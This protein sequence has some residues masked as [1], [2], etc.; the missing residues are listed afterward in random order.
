MPQNNMGQ[1]ESSFPAPA[2]TE[3]QEN[4]TAWQ[5]NRQS[6][7]MPTFQQGIRD[8]L[9]KTP[10]GQALSG[11]DVKTA[12]PI[13]QKQVQEARLTLQKYKSGKA[14]LEQRVVENAQWYK[15]RHWDC[16]RKKESNMVEPTS[17]WL[18]NSIANKHAD[19]MDNFP[20]ANILPRE[21]GDQEE[22]KRL[23]SILPVIL[24]QNDFENTFSDL[25]DDKLIKGTGIYGVFWDGTKLNGLGDVSI[26]NVDIINLFW[27][28]GITDIQQSRNVFFVELMDNEIL[29]DRYP[30]LANKLGGDDG[31]LGKYVYDDNVDTTKKSPVIDW[32]YKKTV[33]GKNILHYCKFVNDEV[34]FA[35]EN[36]AEYRETGWYDDG[37]YPFVFDPLFRS[38]GT[39][40]GFGYIDVA[41]SAQEYIDRGNQAIMQNMLANAR[42]RHFIRTDGAVNE[43]EYAD[44][45]RDFVHVEGSNLGEDSIRAIQGKPLNEIYVSVI[46]NKI[47]E[48]K[49]TTGNRDISTGGTASGVTA[50]SAIA[51]MQEAGSKLSRD[52]NKS[53]YRAFRKMCLMVIERI[54]QFYDLPRQFRIIGEGGA[55]EFVSYDNT[56][57]RPMQQGSIM[58]QDMGIRMPVFDLEVTA[59]KASP[60]T[61]LSQNELALQFYGAGF[62]A[63]QM[64]DAA[65]AC[66]EMMDFDRK[67]NVVKIIKQNQAAYMLQ[68]MGMAL[69]GMAPTA[70]PPDGGAPTAP[71]DNGPQTGEEGE[72]GVTRNARERV[73]GATA[74]R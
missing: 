74:P 43:K 55:M 60:Y 24:D 69:P 65:L 20:R 14:N 25:T 1:G 54:R 6:A 45:T 34:L 61:K 32:Y 19:A 50:A 17:G 67:E 3:E 51:A 29:E 31:V 27:E 2:S 72:S 22:A 41:K 12:K 44:M 11:M 30:Q 58:G 52:N 13:G 36:E 9:L 66:L 47:D 4:Q 42:P 73:A 38:A 28:S 62:F 57:L 5:R 46:N 71:T 8:S 64:A 59:E 49:E 63:P 15:L 68:M 39:P 35:T 10:T 33:N 40:C 18:F 26:R 48:L 23:S 37:Q 56:N 7:P 21:A 16:M 53:S 70:P